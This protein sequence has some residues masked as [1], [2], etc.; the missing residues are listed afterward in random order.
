VV[1]R[2]HGGHFFIENRSDRDHNGNPVSGVRAGFVLPCAEDL[3]LPSQ[4]IQ[5]G[6]YNG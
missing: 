3:S 5:A 1:A 6:E 4:D 2:A